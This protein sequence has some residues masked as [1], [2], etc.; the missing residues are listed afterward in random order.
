MRISLSGVLK[1]ICIIAKIE[2]T[3]Y[4]ILPK[5][6]GYIRSQISFSGSPHSFI[7]DDILCAWIYCLRVRGTTNVCFE[8]S[9][10]QKC[11]AEKRDHILT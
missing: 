8:K 9:S 11:L 3:L 10:I 7:R 1:R 4:Q 2:Q 6:E 5:Y